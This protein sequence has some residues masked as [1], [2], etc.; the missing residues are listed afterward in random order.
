MLYTRIA[1]RFVSFRRVPMK[2]V[3][4]TA[5]MSYALQIGAIVQGQPLFI[6][7]LY[8]LLP[9][10]PL[11]LFEFVWKY[12]H[13]SWV[14]VFFVVTLLQIGHMGE[15]TFQVV[16]LNALSGT[17]ACPPPTD[18][19]ANAQRAIDAGIRPASETATGRSASTVIVPGAGGQPSLDANGNETRGP[20]ACGVFGQLDFET[21]H[22]VWDTAVWLGALWLLTKFPRNIFLWVAMFAASVHEVEHLFIGYV[23]FFDGAEVFNYTRTLWATTLEGRKVVAHPVGQEMALA[24][25]YEAGGKIGIMGRNGLVERL[26]LDSNGALPIRPNLHFIYNLLV[27][28]PTIAAFAWQM[29]RVYDEYLAKALPN[30]TEDQLIRATPKLERFKFEPGQIVVQQG[31]TADRFYIITRGEVE[32]LRELPNGHDVVLARLGPGQYFGEI[33]LLHGGKRIA[34]VRASSDLEVLAL[35][36]VSF[37]EIM[38]ESDVSRSELDKIVRQRVSEVQVAQGGGD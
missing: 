21:V 16:Q 28:T 19:A 15:H 14:A 36:R 12:D 6:I 7:A 3:I 8:T 26:V 5:L 32:V 17:L 9:W 37:S 11:F 31:D 13:Y 1:E 2:A 24:N 10:I 35:D 20:A 4:I 22:L 18:S 33:G 29:R 25:F 30:L 38:T 27:V 34:S 23:Y